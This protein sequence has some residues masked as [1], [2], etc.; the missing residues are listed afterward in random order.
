VRSSIAFGTRRKKRSAN[1]R[2]NH[3]GER[4]LSSRSRL[5]MYIDGETA[6]SHHEEG[7]T[8]HSAL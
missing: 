3:D 4:C 5:S 6:D 1:V 7:H 2:T 8:K